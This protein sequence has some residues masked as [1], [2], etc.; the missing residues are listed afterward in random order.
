MS[1]TI[2]NHTKK[3]VDTCTQKAI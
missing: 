1:T 3:N 2:Q